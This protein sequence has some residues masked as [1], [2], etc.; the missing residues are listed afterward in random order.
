VVTAETVTSV[1]AMPSPSGSLMAILARA[2][3]V[4]GSPAMASAIS[5]TTGMIQRNAARPLAATTPM[6]RNSAPLARPWWAA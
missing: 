1:P 3:P 5:A 4:S 6:P 2:P